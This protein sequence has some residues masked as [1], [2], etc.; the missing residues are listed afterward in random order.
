MKGRIIMEKKYELTDET[1]LV[2]GHILHRIRALKDFGD[3]KAGSAGGFIEKEENLSHEGDCWVFEHACVFEDAYINANAR[4]LGNVVVREN[5]FVSD[6]ACLYG[7]ACILGHAH[8]FDDACVFGNAI[9]DGNAFLYGKARAYGEASISGNA[10][11]LDNA[12]VF[13][14]AHVSGNARVSDGAEICGNA[15]ILG[16]ACILGDACVSNNARVVNNAYITCTR[17]VLFISHIESRYGCGV[18]FYAG[19]DGNIYVSYGCFSKIIEEFEQEIKENL[20]SK[21]Y[22]KEYELAINMAKL[23]I[24]K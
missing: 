17:D 13:N 4:V 7:N 23:H 18:T 5:A 2:E 3:I 15:Q 8:A 11:I 16:N 10:K 19:K 1:M 9:I 12:C 24:L 6:N 14:K 20:M 22:K 21:K